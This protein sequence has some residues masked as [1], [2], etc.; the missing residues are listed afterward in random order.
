MTKAKVIEDL[1]KHGSTEWKTDENGKRY[2]TTC[3]RTWLGDGYAYYC[4]G[5][6]IYRDANP[7]P[8]LEYG[9]EEGMKDVERIYFNDPRLKRIDIDKEALKACIKSHRRNSVSDPMDGFKI[10]YKGALINI[11]PWL[12]QDMCEYV[13]DYAIYIDENWN[14]YPAVCYKKPVYGFSEDFTTIQCITLPVSVSEDK[15]KKCLEV[16]DMEVVE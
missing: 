13:K 16:A 9:I 15:A 4:N 11:N 14:G 8:G 3:F 7:L 12:L 2:G 1:R 5:Y 10:N 6:M